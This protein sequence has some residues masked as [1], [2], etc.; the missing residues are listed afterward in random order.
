MRTNFTRKVHNN[1]Y[2]RVRIFTLIF[3]L[4]CLSFMSHA[5]DMEVS[6]KVTSKTEGDALPG[7]NIVI[8]GTNTG[9]ITDVEG[10][11]KMNIP[12][13]AT[14]IFS[15]V[16]YETQEVLVGNQSIIDVALQVNISSLDEIVVVGYGTVKKKDLTGA[17]SQI[18]A[19]KIAH[20]SPNSLTD[21]LRANIPGLN[22]GFSNS[23]KGVS[24]LEI[25]GKTT[26]NAGASPLIVLDGMI[27]NGDL[28]DINPQDIDKVD[29]MKDASSAAIYG[30]RGSNGVILIT[31]KRGATEKP[32]INISTMFGLAT[33]AF[34]NRPYGPQE[35]ADWRT[36]V[37]NSI[38]YGKLDDTPGMFNRPT[39]LPDG[40]TL[41]D[42]LAYDGATGDPTTAWL[43]RI[44]FQDVEIGNY[45]DNKS[46]DWYDKIFQ[47][48]FRSDVNF[49]LSGQNTGLKYY[50]SIGHTSNEGVI[51]G[52]KFETIRTRLNVEAD[53]VDWLT[54][55]INTQ[56]A[57]R[58]EGS[59]PA[60]WPMFW[61]DSPWGSELSDDGTTLR[62]SP[63]DDSGTGARHPFLRRT[64]TD[65]DR[66]F[67]TLNS[68]MYTRISLPW[69][70]SYEFAFTNRFEWNH[71][72]NH[73]SSESP[74]WATGTA[75]RE[76]RSIHEWQIDNI[77]KWDKTFGDHTFNA[78]FLAYAEKFESFYERSTNSL[79]SPNDKLGFNN[80]F[81]Y[82]SGFSW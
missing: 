16:G 82:C 75:F 43:N 27:Y 77:L 15:Y 24:Q 33:P 72:F 49:S 13:G 4:T 40:V 45:H 62:F 61:R 53:V 17:V 37:F 76:R 25:R 29:V 19:S 21:V 42:W 47:N 70:F 54:V 8:Q 50:W 56:F 68:R 5:Q 60:E 65:R 12:D 31:T 79:F 57:I 7:V 81:R 1:P 46:V 39:D 41:E 67:N 22:V 18:D 74:E 58:D 11:Y 28:S 64:Y 52:E 55:G 3:G 32:T 73:Q 78:T 34:E 20:Q 59:V 44:G 30:S 23:P 14:L 36:E 26:L 69:G 10:N 80:L 63:Q 35:Y 66:K 38:N 51:V 71:Y 2:M 9:A 6:G 48:G